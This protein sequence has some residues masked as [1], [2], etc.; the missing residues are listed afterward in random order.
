M[1]S[2]FSSAISGLKR[3][4]QAAAAAAQSIAS[5]GLEKT[6]PDASKSESKIGSSDSETSLAED[7]VNLS[8]AE[9]SFKANIKVIEAEQENQ[10][11]VLDI[12]A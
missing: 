5:R 2:T 3:S 8:V 12:L 6:T 9:S 4:Q 10:Q 1:S 11:A 7:I